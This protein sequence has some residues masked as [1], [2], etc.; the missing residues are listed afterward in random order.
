MPDP[1]SPRHAIP[2]PATSGSNDAVYV[3]WLRRHL[4]LPVA[5]RPRFARAICINLDSKA[6]RIGEVHSFTDEMI[7]HSRVRA[8]FT[9]MLNESAERRTIG[10]QNGEM[11]ETEQS[12]PWNGT[13]SFLLDELDQHTIFTVRSE[14]RHRISA[15][16]DAHPENR[17]VVRSRQPQIANLKPDSSN[18]RFVGKSE[19][20]RLDAN[21]L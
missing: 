15:P 9:E 11:I 5:Q 4:E 2:L 3:E 20:R 18:M 7:R 8:D 10:K 21:L 13:H 1:R 16:Q 12:A 19:S 6:I 14:L 17:L